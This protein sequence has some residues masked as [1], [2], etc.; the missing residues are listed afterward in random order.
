MIPVVL[1]AAAL[2]ACG[3]SAPA[4]GQLPPTTAE[5][6]KSWLATAEYKSW[7]CEP[8]AHPARSPSP[9]SANRICQNDLASAHG[10]GEYPS[11]AASV[12]ELFDAGGGIRGHSVS[13]HVSEGT[14]GGS[15]YWFDILGG[16]GTSDGA[17]DS[18]AP[19]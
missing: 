18:P 12:K 5:E 16:T 9:H 17:R 8:A 11:G 14:T 13:R 3:R 1:L 15:C 10:A 19:Q 7:H 6:L 2:N 4:S